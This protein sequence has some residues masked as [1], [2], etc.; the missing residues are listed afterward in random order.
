VHLRSCVV[1]VNFF[2]S[3]IVDRGSMSPFRDLLTFASFVMHT[4]IVLTT[5]SQVL[6]L[7]RRLIYRPYGLFVRDS[8]DLR[9][10][11]VIAHRPGP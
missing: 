1:S 11:L 5:R 6:P 2:T 4:L 3:G 10:F 8:M 9:E 7:L